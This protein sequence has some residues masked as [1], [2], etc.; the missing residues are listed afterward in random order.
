MNGKPR[1][2]WLISLIIRRR[3][4]SMIMWPSS[5]CRV[6]SSETD[7][8]PSLTSLFFFLP[9]AE[10]LAAIRLFRRSRWKPEENTTSTRRQT[11]SSASGR[12]TCWR[13]AAMKWSSRFVFPRLR[14][15][16]FFRPDR[17]WACRTTG[18]KPRWTDTK[19]SCRKTT[20]RCR[21]RGERPFSSSLARP[22]QNQIK[23][24]LCFLLFNSLFTGLSITSVSVPY[25][26]VSQRELSAANRATARQD[27]I[28]S[29]LSCQT[30]L[31]YWRKPA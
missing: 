20:S 12:A 7:I 31:P 1:P 6:I 19:D 14:D 22:F 16:L 25:Y 5:S 29:R 11:T 18:A 9:C 17:F 13:S 30:G 24:T 8:L 15:F 10:T 21:L 23:S 28:I 4:L 3:G 26:R 27:P 2:D